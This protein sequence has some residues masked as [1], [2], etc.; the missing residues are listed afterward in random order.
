MKLYHLNHRAR[1]QKGTPTTNREEHSE[2]KKP[3]EHV[4]SGTGRQVRL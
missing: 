2:S 4:C 1:D 3:E